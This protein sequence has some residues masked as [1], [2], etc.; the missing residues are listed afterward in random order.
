MS[1][2]TIAKLEKNKRHDTILNLNYDKTIKY[3]KFLGGAKSKKLF[4]RNVYIEDKKLL[5]TLVGDHENNLVKKINS[6]IIYPIK[7]GSTVNKIE[8]M[9][10]EYGGNNFDIKYI[11]D[12]VL[13]DNT[14]SYSTF[15]KLDE[16]KCI[17]K[18]KTLEETLRALKDDYIIDKGYVY[19]KVLII[20]FIEFILCCG[21][22]YEDNKFEHYK[23]QF[24]IP[25]VNLITSI[26]HYAIFTQSYVDDINSCDEKLHI[27][28]YHNLECEKDKLK[29]NYGNEAQSSK[30]YITI[31]K[32]QD[33]LINRY[34]YSVIL[35][36]KIT[37]KVKKFVL[38]IK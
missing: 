18:A 10:K 6:K 36:N 34:G 14:K 35:F 2:K 4:Y 37:Y 20:R 32:K 24:I 17:D 1:S 5:Q 22:F 11:K 7:G 8:R 19:W 38:G 12:L 9:E 25:I 26:K 33:N 13:M 27:Y 16:T 3:Y 21:N 31:I 23:Q 15:C 29:E 28:E 30:D